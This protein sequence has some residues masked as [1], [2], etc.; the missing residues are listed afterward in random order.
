M[1][2]RRALAA[3]ELEVLDLEDELAAAKDAGAEGPEFMDLKRKLREARRIHRT[4]R[5][6]D[7]PAG[8]VARPATVEVTGEVA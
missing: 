3:A 6:G 4:L 7:N 2:D 1:T 8:G 5:E